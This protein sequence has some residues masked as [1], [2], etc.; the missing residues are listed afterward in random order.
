MKKSLIIFLCLLVH[1]SSISQN[2]EPAP[3]DKAVVYFASPYISTVGLMGFLY[4]IPIY[5]EEGFGIGFLTYR[6]FIRYECDPGSHYFWTIKGV[7]VS[8]ISA[9]K[10]DLEPGK[11][12]LILAQQTLLPDPAGTITGLTPVD[13]TTE[14]EE[15][16]DM[17]KVL[18]AKSSIKANKMYM[19]R[20]DKYIHA[21]NKNKRKLK[22][23]ELF[24]KKIDK[25]LDKDKCKI[26]PPHWYI[27]PE[28][29]YYDKKDKKGEDDI[30]T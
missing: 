18:N 4:Q 5:D 29:M 26:L 21:L 22:S 19:K 16:F 25:V 9:I 10:A 13:T 28:Q 14:N 17:L 23:Y 2:F 11:I 30:E 20:Q 1:V 8:S 27:E 12:Y 6:N 3:P 7:Y 24:T 15:L